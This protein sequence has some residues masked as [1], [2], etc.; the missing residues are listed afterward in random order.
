M[1]NI[2]NARERIINQMTVLANELRRLQTS[3]PHP[4]YEKV[5]KSNTGNYDPSQN[6]YWYDCTCHE[7]GKNWW[8]DQ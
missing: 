1:S 5:A 7:C 3:C 2:K 8:I 6:S 4:N